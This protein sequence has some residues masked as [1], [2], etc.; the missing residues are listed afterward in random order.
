[1]VN[2]DLPWNP[3]RIEQCFGRIHRFLQREVCHLWN[4]VA[5]QTREGAVYQR[6]LEK[7]ENERKALGGKVFEVLGRAFTEIALRDLMIEAVRY[8]RTED[9]TEWM[10][11]KIDATWD[12]AFLKRLVQ[13]HALNTTTIKENMERAEA[14]RLVPHFIEAFFVEAFERLGGSVRQRGSPAGMRLPVCP[15]CC[16]AGPE[17]G[18]APGCNQGTSEFV[19]IRQIDMSKGSLRQPSSHQATICS[20]LSA[21]KN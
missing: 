4:L 14:R 10:R 6:L 20:T 8:N 11:L 9:A 12:E 15:R 5:H 16:A 1:M 7:L 21:R 13:E 2:Y 19:S 17:R 18:V 3:N